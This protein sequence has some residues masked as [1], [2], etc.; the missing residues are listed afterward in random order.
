MLILYSGRGDKGAAARGQQF[1]YLV[2][3]Y[4]GYSLPVC[5]DSGMKGAGRGQGYLVGRVQIYLYVCWKN[6]WRHL[7][8]DRLGM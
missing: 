6:L 3:W 5:I 7:L 2:R 8:N 1:I 4:G